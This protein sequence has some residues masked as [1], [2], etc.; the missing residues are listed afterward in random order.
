MILRWFINGDFGTVY[1][2]FAPIMLLGVATGTSLG[3]IGSRD[4]GAIG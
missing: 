3:V 4:D 2:M 1:E